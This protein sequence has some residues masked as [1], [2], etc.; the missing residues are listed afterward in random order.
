[1]PRNIVGPPARGDDCFGRQ[2]FVEQLEQRLQHGSV[3][4]SAPRRWGKTSVLRKLVDRQPETR[5]YFDLYPYNRASD[6]VAELAAATAT[7]A[8]GIAQWVAETLG[9]PLDHI[10]NVKVGDVAIEL[11][12]HLASA[13][14]WEPAGSHAYASLPADHVLVLDEFPVMVKAILDRDPGEAEALLRWLRTE[15]QRDGAARIVVAGSTSLPELCREAGL[16]HTIND[17]TLLPL[18]RL[19]RATAFRLL[20]SVLTTESV[21]LDEGA[22]EAAVDLVGPEVPFFVQLIAQAIIAEIRDTPPAHPA[23]TVSPAVLRRLYDTVLLSPRNRGY[24]DD[25]RGRLDRSYLPAERDLALLLLRSLAVRRNGLSL[26]A[27]RNEASAKGL[28][29]GALDRVLVLLEGDFYIVREDDGLYRFFN[30]YL[31][32]WWQRFHA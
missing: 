8:T 7:R 15:R 11:R 19:D 21:R 10:K 23:R 29:V 31:A 16:S 28:D 26:R 25:Y 24:L 32:D 3:L 27:L 22:I 30:R 18:P 4:L 20:G 1:M 2:H 5:H 12:D 14:D 17:L 13:A 6:F 9:R